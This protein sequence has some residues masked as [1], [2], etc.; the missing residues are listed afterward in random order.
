MVGNN[1]RMVCMADR[2]SRPYSPLHAVS[3]LASR[4][5]VSCGMLM[6]IPYVA[7]CAALDC[8]S[9]ML[10]LTFFRKSNGWWMI[11]NTCSNTSVADGWSGSFDGGCHYFEQCV[12]VHTLVIT[13]IGCA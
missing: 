7:I 9:S 10:T 6:T 13:A 8:I 1:F 2:N 5:S 4:V 11:S 3:M 12:V